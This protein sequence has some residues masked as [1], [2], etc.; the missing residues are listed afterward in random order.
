MNAFR[1]RASIPL[2]ESFGKGDLKEARGFRALIDGS[3][4]D[5]ALMA[6][7]AG[8]APETPQDMRFGVSE[9][10]A[11]TIEFEATLEGDGRVTWASG[12]PRLAAS[13]TSSA[14]VRSAKSASMS[15]SRRSEA[16]TRAGIES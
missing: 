4:V 5:P 10:G 3:P 13:S 7:V 6:Y 12:I 15:G 8:C 2:T 11:T 16:A 9:M 1:S 14:A